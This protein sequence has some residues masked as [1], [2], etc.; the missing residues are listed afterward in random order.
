MPSEEEEAMGFGGEKDDMTEEV[1][2][3]DEV[4]RSGLTRGDEVAA[5]AAGMLAVGKSRPTRSS[6]PSSS[7]LMASIICVAEWEDEL[8]GSKAC[9]P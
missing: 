9:V 3:D 5:W 8:L 1:P 4:P 2:P 7:P 6:A